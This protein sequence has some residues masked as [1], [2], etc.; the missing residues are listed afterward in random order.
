M[1]FRSPIPQCW[2]MDLSCWKSSQMQLVHRYSPLLTR[3]SQLTKLHDFGTLAYCTTTHVIYSQLSAS[4]LMLLDCCLLYAPCFLHLLSPHKPQ[5]R[6][7]VR[8]FR[9]GYSATQRD[10]FLRYSIQH[11]FWIMVEGWENLTS[12]AT[13]IQPRAH[14]VHSY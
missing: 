3:I 9:F 13:L 10:L 4:C 11:I 12:D 7:K 2:S 5:R 1:F 8:K 6:G 14:G